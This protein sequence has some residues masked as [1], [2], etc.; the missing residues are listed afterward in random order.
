MFYA[1]PLDGL[2]LEAPSSQTTFVLPVKDQPHATYF[3]SP[4]WSAHFKRRVA[5]HQDFPGL[6]PQRET[7]PA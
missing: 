1:G 6:P 3:T 4:A 7:Q 2:Q 5:T